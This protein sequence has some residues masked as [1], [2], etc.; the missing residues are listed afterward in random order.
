MM[1]VTQIA[2]NELKTLIDAKKALVLDVRSNS[3][4][5]RTG[6]IPGAICIPAVE[7]RRRARPDSNEFDP[8]FADAKTIV[9]FCAIGARSAAVAEVLV[10]IGYGDVRNLG[11]FSDW[12]GAG[13]PVARLSD[14]T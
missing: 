10:E 1:T 13:L 4:I 3:E 12:T 5:E 8:V 11:K 9:V 7:V 2:P 14:P 6:T